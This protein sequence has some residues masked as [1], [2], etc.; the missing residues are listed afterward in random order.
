MDRRETLFG[1]LR[2]LFTPVSHW[3]WPSTNV[4]EKYDGQRVT[5]VVHLKTGQ[6]RLCDPISLRILSAHEETVH[7]KDM[8]VYLEAQNMVDTQRREKQGKAWDAL[9][10]HP[11]AMERRYALMGTVAPASL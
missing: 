9:I 10:N 2:E 8:S 5:Y 1:W 11:E 6:V 4:H 7:L 3:S